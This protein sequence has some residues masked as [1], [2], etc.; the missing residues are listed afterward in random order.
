VGYLK[1]A[2]VRATKGNKNTVK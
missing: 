2:D 1:T